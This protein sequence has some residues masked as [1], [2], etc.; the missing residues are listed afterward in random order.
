MEVEKEMK[1]LLKNNALKEPTQSEILKYP[2]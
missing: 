1:S 2:F